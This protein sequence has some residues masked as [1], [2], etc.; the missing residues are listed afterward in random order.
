[1]IRRLFRDLLGGLRAGFDV[2]WWSHAYPS[3]SDMQVTY[4]GGLSVRRVE[5]RRTTEWFVDG[6]PVSEQYAKACMQ[7]AED[8]LRR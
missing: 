7:G 3:V 1:M 8:R 4:L 6:Q 2:L 5:D